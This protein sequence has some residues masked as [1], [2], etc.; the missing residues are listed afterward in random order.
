MTMTN[1]KIEKIEKVLNDVLAKLFPVDE[2]ET[3]RINSARVTC[4]RLKAFDR[5]KMKTQYDLDAITLS[6]ARKQELSNVQNPN[7]GAENFTPR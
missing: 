2:G 3:E 5:T 4:S 7:G 6:Q 1:N